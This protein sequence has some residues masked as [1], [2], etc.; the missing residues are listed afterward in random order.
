MNHY[1]VK[2]MTDIG[3]TQT[4]LQIVSQIHTRNADGRVNVFWI[5]YVLWR[6]WHHG[7]MTWIHRVLFILYLGKAIF[8]WPLFVRQM[9]VLVDQFMM[10]SRP[11][12]T[13]LCWSLIRLYLFLLRD[14][15]KLDWHST[16]NTDVFVYLFFNNDGV[17]L[18]KNQTLNKIIWLWT[19][20]VD[21]VLSVT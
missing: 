9:F 11:Y 19:A 3:Q 1:Q 12:M 4:A 21:L 10:V 17:L 18:N 5:T 15:F 2:A 6:E 14:L 20:N 13:K 7:P 8:G 16:M